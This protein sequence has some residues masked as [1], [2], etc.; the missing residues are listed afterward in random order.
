MLTQEQVA[1]YRRE[2]FLVIPGVISDEDIAELK[3]VTTDFVEQARAV[4]EHTSVFDLEPLHTAERPL[5]RRIKT[6]EKWHPVYARMV[7]HPVI[8]EALADL[9]G[10]GV[11]FHASKLNLKVAGV[12]S[13]LE[14]HQDWAFYPHTNEDLAVVGIMIDTIDEENGAMMV[15]PGSHQGPLEDH[16]YNGVFTGGI[17]PARAHTDFSKAVSVCGKEGSISIHHPRLVHGGPANRSGRD[18]RYLLNQYRAADAWP[19]TE[20]VDWPEWRANLLTGEETWT[21]R[22]KDLPV[23]LPFPEPTHGGSIYENQRDL[24]TRYFDDAAR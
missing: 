23:R 1:D 11:R 14:W 4:T 21:P 7:R 22:L 18:R 13:S 17:D 9:W 5:V 15:V 12:G 2:G 20:T 10:T 3:A 19:L 8:L 24:R 16:S 6:P